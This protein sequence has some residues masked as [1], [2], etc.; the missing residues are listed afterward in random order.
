MQNPVEQFAE[1]LCAAKDKPFAK[2]EQKRFAGVSFLYVQIP[3]EPGAKETFEAFL[4][5][6]A[7]EFV[8]DTAWTYEFEY[9]RTS[10]QGLIYR[11]RFRVPE[12]KSFCCG[13]E[14]P[15]CILRRL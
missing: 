15:N 9:I 13:N 12:E 4:R 3:D 5:K 11:Y 7:E 2:L 1:E 8:Q 10:R 14:C 6:R